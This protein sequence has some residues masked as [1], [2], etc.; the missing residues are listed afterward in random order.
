[1]KYTSQDS[2]R[3]IV[4]LFRAEY[5]NQVQEM[6]FKKEWPPFIDSSFAKMNYADLDII[7]FFAFQKYLN[8]EHI[9]LE[10]IREEVEASDEKNR[11][12]RAKTNKN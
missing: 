11:Q 3:S 2:L 6:G 5:Y 1:M 10:E 7:M 12:I 4:H 8:N 9:D